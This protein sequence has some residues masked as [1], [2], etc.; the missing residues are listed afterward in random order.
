MS[1]VAALFAIAVSAALIIVLCLGDPKRCRAAGTPGRELTRSRRWGLAALAL[2]PGLLCAL[3]GDAAASLIWLGGC[4][5]SGWG[6]ALRAPA[7]TAA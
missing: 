2:A 1:L 6:A 4:V 5:L 7:K 3:S